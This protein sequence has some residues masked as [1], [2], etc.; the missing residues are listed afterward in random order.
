[1]A[2]PKLPAPTSGPSV[3]SYIAVCIL[4]AAVVLV[5]LYGS[6]VVLPSGLHAFRDVL[7][8]RSR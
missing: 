8:I 6:G 5:V 2:A 4:V 1:L 3:A 7:G